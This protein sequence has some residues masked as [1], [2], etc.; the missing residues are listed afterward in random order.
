MTKWKVALVIIITLA[1]AL[2][3]SFGADF[4]HASLQSDGD[5][6]VKKEIIDFS[7]DTRYLGNEYA[8]G[9]GTISKNYDIK[10][11]LSLD[12]SAEI[13]VKNGYENMATVS[14]ASN[15]TVKLKLGDEYG[16][17]V[18]TVTAGGKSVDC[19]FVTIEGVN[20]TCA[21]DLYKVC[22][23][24]GIT[25]RTVVLQNNIKLSEVSDT[26]DYRFDGGFY[27]NGFSVD[28]SDYVNAQF[29]GSA[30]KDWPC[31]TFR[32]N[33]VTVRDAYFYGKYYSTGENVILRDL[34]DC[35]VAAL[36]LGSDNKEVAARVENC[37][38][39]NF[40]RCA[41]IQNAD[42]YFAGCLF[43][44]ASV[45]G[46]AI[47]TD[48]IRASDVTMENSAIANTL[49]AG[50]C[51]WCSK[52]VPDNCQCTVTLKGFVDFYCWK[53]QN[54]AVIMPES[55]AM[56]NAVNTSFKAALADNNN[57]EFLYNY[58]SIN[59]ISVAIL[60]L[61]TSSDG[62][63]KTIFYNTDGQGLGSLNVR[64]IFPA[65]TLALSSAYIY[66]YSNSSLISPVETLSDNPYLYYEMKNGR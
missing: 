53:S 21:R 23:N 27:G 51:S 55:E 34:E 11:V 13:A 5:V 19:E 48:D 26:F 59:Y 63:N 52:A 44:N 1:V 22:Y 61:C 45:C 28:C 36:F 64:R 6:T 40:N 17:L 42:V 15:G 9:T 49:V 43:Q 50:I 18:L 24:G 29:I 65:V 33:G 39:E 31:M 57:S 25:G 16:R 56:A 20:V 10:K 38:F 12:L 3:V 62:K 35:G 32:G 14:V 37:V 58:N 30:A 60:G 7:A 4:L 66:G 8:L 47:H 46:I 41:K 2:G 54:N